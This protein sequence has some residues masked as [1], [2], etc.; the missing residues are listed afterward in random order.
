[1]AGTETMR[2]PRAEPTPLAPQIPTALRAY[3]PEE[4]DDKKPK[5]EGDRGC[6]AAACF[7]VL[8]EEAEI[9]GAKCVAAAMDESA[10]GSAGDEGERLR[11]E[12]F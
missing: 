4:E 8:V 2:A 1:M 7:R 3:N 6:K 10:K 5:L 11:N 12:G 9:E